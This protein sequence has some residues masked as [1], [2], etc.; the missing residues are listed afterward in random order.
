[1]VH[2]QGIKANLE[3]IQALID[4]RSPNSV[5]EVQ[6]L[7]GKVA[8]LSHFVSKAMN[9]CLPFFNILWRSKKFKFKWNVESRK[10][11]RA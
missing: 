1:M 10:L 3:K 8:A 2:E 11:F 4:M 5:K 6:S 7:I 9:K